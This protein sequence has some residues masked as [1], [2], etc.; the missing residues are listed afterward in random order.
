LHH[1]YGLKSEVLA[2]TLFAKVAIE[3]PSYFHPPS[4]RALHSFDPALSISA[5][6]PYLYIF[7]DP[8]I[9]QAGTAVIDTHNSRFLAVLA[10]VS[11]LVKHPSQRVAKP[12]PEPHA[13]LNEPPSIFDD[14]I[15]HHR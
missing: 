3:F 1:R 14:R 4:R 6:V 12:T 9:F 8:T 7:V 13:E 2:D 5:N 15:V 11:T 10:A